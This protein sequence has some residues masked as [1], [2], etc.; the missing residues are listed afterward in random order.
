[1]AQPTPDWFNDLSTED[2]GRVE[3]IAEILGYAMQDHALVIARGEFRGDNVR[4]IC[5]NLPDDDD[6]DQSHL[7]PV[8]ILL[9][10]AWD[11]DLILLDAEREEKARG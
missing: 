5:V 1:M 10:H 2:R 6:P 11:D 4:A 8:A 7:H 9:P 3:S